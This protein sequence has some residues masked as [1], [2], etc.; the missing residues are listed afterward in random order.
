MEKKSL[1]STGPLPRIS[2]TEGDTLSQDR[3]IRME[4]ALAGA[5]RHDSPSFAAIVEEYQAMV[6][7][8][9]YHFLQDR[10]TAEDVAQDVFLELYQKVSTIQSAAHLTFWL[11]RVAVHRAIDQGR[12]KKHRSETSLEGVLETG[13]GAP[14]NLMHDTM[15]HDTMIRDPIIH[16][17]M[18]N[19]Q[20]QQSLAALP[21]KQRM[22]VVLRYQEDLGPA[23]I[24]ELL[25]MPVNT[26]KS[27]LHRSLGELRRL[28][29][30]K[31]GEI[32]YAFF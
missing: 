27:T 4:A 1:H 14:R 8:I 32:R 11:R 12:R 7:S 2:S 20:L 13:V 29:T 21:E 17:P 5:A 22:I 30:R 16:D 15:I 3:E 24:A 18:L 31:L 6:F 10:G 26:V 9:A 23:E 28:L 25:Q 19:G